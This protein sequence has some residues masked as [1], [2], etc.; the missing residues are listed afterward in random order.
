MK[1]RGTLKLFLIPVL[2][3][4]FGFLMVPLYNVFCNVTGINGKT[5]VISAAEA[6][7]TPEALNRDI[8][9]EFTSSV[10]QDGPWEFHSAQPSMMIHPG[11]LYTTSYIARN[12]TDKPLVTQAIPSVAPGKA[13]SHFKKTECFCF[14]QQSFAAGEQREMSLSF[15]VN[16]ELPDDVDTITLSYTLFTLDSELIKPTPTDKN[17]TISLSEA[18]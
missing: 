14:T 5:G 12:R 17:S 18:K 8:K 6:S 16:P 15:I 10:N 9:V 1:R 2:M 4:G 13:A 11:K 7:M 3:F